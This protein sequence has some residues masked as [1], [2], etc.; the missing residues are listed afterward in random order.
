MKTCHSRRPQHSTPTGYI[1]RDVETKTLV[2]CWTLVELEVYRFVVYPFIVVIKQCWKQSEVFQLFSWCFSV[3]S[4]SWNLI[5]SCSM[6][7]CESYK[8]NCKNIGAEIVSVRVECSLQVRD[9]R[10][11]VL[12]A[13]Y[14]Y[15]PMWVNYTLKWNDI[16]AMCCSHLL[17][18]DEVVVFFLFSLDHFSLIL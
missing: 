11:F 16:A 14:M 13:L 18:K 1:Q 7:A 6:T 12:V 4:V 17:S 10:Y 15:L 3:L 2:I 5:F 9:Q 8:Y